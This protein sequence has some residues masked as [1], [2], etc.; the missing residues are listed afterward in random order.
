LP[1]KEGLVFNVM[2]CA[3]RHD[4]IDKYMSITGEAIDAVM[5]DTELKIG[6]LVNR[7]DEAQ[8]QTVMKLDGLLARSGPLLKLAA[9]D[10]VMTT[11]SRILDLKTV[12]RMMVVVMR[13]VL[14]RAAVPAAAAGEACEGV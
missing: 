7:M 2:A 3:Y 6:D 12:R 13:R 1:L 11:L 14:T 10:R 5:R 8:E 9:N 4:V